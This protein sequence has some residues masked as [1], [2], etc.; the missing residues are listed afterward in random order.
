MEINELY[1]KMATSLNVRFQL[2]RDT[3]ENWHLSAANSTDEAVFRPLQPGEPGF[4]TTNNEMRIGDGLSRW[5]DLPVVRTSVVMTEYSYSMDLVRT[6]EDAFQR[7]LR[8][9]EACFDR[10]RNQIRIGDGIT[11]FRD[12]PFYVANRNDPII[13]DAFDEVNNA[14]KFTLYL[15]GA[16]V[17][18]GARLFLYY[19]DDTSQWVP[20]D[21][22]S[23]GVAVTAS[24]GPATVSLTAGVVLQSGR[25][26]RGQVMKSGDDKVYFSSPE[27]QYG[28]I[29][30]NDVTVAGASRFT[31]LYTL[32]DDYAGP[33]LYAH[34]FKTTNPNSEAT[35][36]V[37][38]TDSALAKGIAQTYSI[39]Y[40]PENG[41]Y[42]SVKVMDGIDPNTADVI[43][44][45]DI[46]RIS[47]K[48]YTN[49][50]VTTNSVNSSY[51]S[52]NVTVDRD[53]TNSYGGSNNVTLKVF[54]SPFSI[55]ADLPG[56]STETVEVASLAVNL[57]TSRRTTLNVS[58]DDI[59]KPGEYFARAY[60]NA[61][62]SAGSLAIE[63]NL[64]AGGI[65]YEPARFS[66]TNPMTVQDSLTASLRLYQPQASGRTLVAAVFE[67]DTAGQASSS[68]RLRQSG[69]SLAGLSGSETNYGL[70][71]PFVNG[72]YYAAIVY[73]SSESAVPSSALAITSLGPLNIGTPTI[74]T[75]TVTAN[76]VSVGFSLRSNRDQVP[77]FTAPTFLVEYLND[78]TWV[79]LSDYVTGSTLTTSL[80]DTLATV[81]CNTLLPT[82]SYRV[83]MNGTSLQTVPVSFTL[84]SSLDIDQP[85]TTTSAS[86]SWAST[87]IVSPSNL[88]FRL[89]R[90]GNSTQTFGPVTTGNNSIAFSGLSTANAL[91][92]QLYI[93]ALFGTSYVLQRSATKTVSAAGVNMNTI[94]ILN[95]LQVRVNFDISTSTVFG[96]SNPTIEVM[97][98]GT[99]TVYGSTT[100]TKSATSATITTT[101]LLF[102]RRYVA[103]ISLSGVYSGS[104]GATAVYSP[105]TLGTPAVY[106]RR[107][108]Q[109]PITIG[110][111]TNFTA[112]TV[113]LQRTYNAATV[114]LYTSNSAVPV[115]ANTDR[116]I[117]GVDVIA[118]GNTIYIDGVPSAT[119]T[120]ALLVN[121]V[122]VASRT[123]AA[124]G[125][126]NFVNPTSATAIWKYRSVEL[127]YRYVS[128]S[129]TQYPRILKPTFRIGRGASYATTV[130][131]TTDSLLRTS[132]DVTVNANTFDS[133]DYTQATTFEFLQTIAN[134]GLR[135]TIIP[136]SALIEDDYRV[137]LIDYDGTIDASATV[138]FR[139]A[140]ITA[141]SLV[142]I[143]FNTISMTYT[144]TDS[145]KAEF[146]ANRDA[147]N[148]FVAVLTGGG[149]R[150]G[151]FIQVPTTTVS[152]LAITSE[153]TLTTTFANN[154]SYYAQL[155]FRN[156]ASYDPITTPSNSVTFVRADP[157]VTGF[158]T[159]SITNNRLRITCTIRFS[160]ATNGT[161]GTNTWS[162]T[163]VP[164]LGTTVLNGSSYSYAFVDS[165]RLTNVSTSASFPKSGTSAFAIGSEIL[166]NQ[167][168]RL[169]MNLRT[170]QR[171]MSD[172][173]LRIGFST[174]TLAA[175]NNIPTLSTSFANFNY[176]PTTVTA[177]AANDALQ[178][179][180]NTLVNYLQ[181]T[182]S[183]RGNSATSMRFRLRNIT[184]S[185][186]VIVLDRTFTNIPA[187]LTST[188]MTVNI[189]ASGTI[190]PAATAVSEWPTTLTLRTTD[191]GIEDG[192]FMIG[193]NYSL[194]I[195]YG[196][197]PSLS[198]TETQRY[199]PAGYD[200]IIYAGQ[201]N[202]YGCD[203]LTPAAQNDPNMISDNTFEAAQLQGI[204]VY[205]FVGGNANTLRTP[206][207]QPQSSLNYYYS[208]KSSGQNTTDGA[209]NPKAVPT[210]I[211]MG[212]EF[213]KF[214]RRYVLQQNR[215][216][217][218][219]PIPVGNTGFDANGLTM[220]G[221][222]DEAWAAGRRARREMLTA[223]TDSITK[224]Y[225]SANASLPGQFLGHN[226][227][228]T[229]LWHQGE[230]DSQA[231]KDSVSGNSGAWSTYLNDMVFGPVLTPSGQM[232]SS[233][234]A[235]LSIA[236][237]NNSSDAKYEIR[238]LNSWKLVLGQM[239]WT[240]SLGGN[241]LDNEQKTQYSNDLQREISVYD[242]GKNRVRSVSSL[243]THGLG[244]DADV[245]DR[246]IHMSNRSQRLMGL[247]YFQAF[248][249]M[250]DN[251]TRVTLPDSF[252]V[253]V[254]SYV[255]PIYTPI[256]ALPRPL[257]SR[258]PDI[259]NLYWTNMATHWQ[260]N[261]NPVCYFVSVRKASVDY[262]GVFTPYFFDRAAS[263]LNGNPKLDGPPYT[264]EPQTLDGCW[265]PYVTEGSNVVPRLFKISGTPDV[266]TRTNVRLVESDTTITI[267]APVFP[268][269]NRWTVFTTNFTDISSVYGTRSEHRANLVRFFLQ[270]PGLGGTLAGA[271]VSIACIGYNTKEAFFMRST[272]LTR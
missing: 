241:Y 71:A 158:S 6:F 40:A 232:N 172:A 267:S 168:Y 177:F 147:G 150:L 68:W 124:I 128:L 134:R 259:N 154:T 239:L 70:S 78:D 95:N 74:G 30:L 175:A 50:R 191:D 167:D 188:P 21:V 121:G 43:T 127:S 264:W 218:V 15:N 125:A 88:R 242:D 17:P 75:A 257:S 139:P 166:L 80:T 9:G 73:D 79:N 83:S 102:G 252:K 46:A 262:V 249:D 174:S 60:F 235:T 47:K 245:G 201:S 193:Y 248:L 132:S 41:E 23:V 171:L 20:Y 37:S 38:R 131:S 10:E 92:D 165:I 137:E 99:T 64:V 12:L 104:T 214:Y 217:I 52:V 216:I 151:D 28:K 111:T 202:M 97:E 103:K 34:L 155:F 185:P 24:N 183:F 143:G 126:S 260:D 203:G 107:Y 29:L 222:G 16:N 19:L 106:D 186:D 51:R 149:A 87:F 170:D 223:L 213:V 237:G 194:D 221:G 61:G 215:K 231:G 182:F 196:D 133:V 197:Y 90:I 142:N 108:F 250:T 179:L 62:D 238:N 117:R 198:E 101:P 195:F 220:P 157:F 212:Q 152:G 233:I 160:N 136:T 200:V 67:Y 3:A 205:D 77:F 1:S 33:D 18:S 190:G 254:N 244:Y 209:P 39:N 96:N 82:G 135:A 162:K 56:Y 54:R 206:S 263:A 266:W 146:Q 129:P 258:Y 240:W 192:K 229:V 256:A 119:Y 98:Y 211:S 122:V 253:F 36:F 59:P 169:D 93:E 112:P 144:M 44:S 120:V 176:I 219:L 272:F 42:F 173:R 228:V 189:Y 204:Y 69:I 45:F 65:I 153:Y 32:A 81:T 89:T 246:S 164:V 72:K 180:S 226:R 199:V 224:V 57:G 86:G 271:T 113:R 208:F 181:Y 13:L 91:D 270:Y 76:T 230:Y 110:T 22:L 161:T 48:L 247:R 5:D 234:A 35:T 187:T 159:A 265:I 49:A 115:V 14:V 4:D 63:R 178:G 109:L 261:F 269:A 116:T 184:K 53:M 55:H 141:F 118:N 140:D 163:F 207:P 130:A 251:Y 225:P 2:R 255:S 26:Y 25:T 148:I 66:S 27:L 58:L 243:G 100:V 156:G 138:T 84:F 114:T 8:P 236:A 31:G 7:K 268:L 123:T 210:T 94:T 145:Q 227:L 85:S 11:A 105:I